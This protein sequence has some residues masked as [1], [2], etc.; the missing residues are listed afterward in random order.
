[1]TTVGGHKSIPEKVPGEQQEPFSFQGYHELPHLFHLA[2]CK[3]VLR[4]STSA[5]VTTD[6][7][8]VETLQQGGQM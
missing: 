8:R 7:L 1:M 2:H 4:P 3:A 5:V 6:R